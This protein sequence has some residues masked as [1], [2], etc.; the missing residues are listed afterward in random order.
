MTRELDFVPVLRKV[1]LSTIK[2]TI[3]SI[4]RDEL[5]LNLCDGCDVDGVPGPSVGELHR[6]FKLKK[7][8]SNSPMK[9]RISRKRDSLESLAVTLSSFRTRSQRMA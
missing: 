2:S 7:V 1:F 4:P 9:P 3:D 8:F 5:I 6:F